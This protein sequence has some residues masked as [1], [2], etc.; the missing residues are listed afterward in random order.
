MIKRIDHVSIVTKDIDKTASL[1]AALF[2]FEAFETHTV[3]EQGFRSTLMR[4]DEVFI[5]LVE[6]LDAESPMARF[7]GNRES[8]LHHFS[9]RV[10]DIEKEL[11]SLK[12]KGIRLVSEKPSQVSETVSTNFI[13]PS[14]LGGVLVELIERS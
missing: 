8:A 3:P 1:L 11:E 7:L 12:A 9:L 10:N 5:E 14:S 2:G 13:H 6:P 4:K